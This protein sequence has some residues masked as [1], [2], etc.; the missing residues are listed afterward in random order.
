MANSIDTSLDCLVNYLREQNLDDEVFNKTSYATDPLSDACK[1]RIKSELDLVFIDAHQKYEDKKEFKKQIDC[2]ID[3]IK[4]DAK[5]KHFLL[6]KKAIESIKLSWR[7]KLN[8]KNWI[9]G[10]KKKALKS[11][12]NDIYA[13]EFE[14]LFVCEYQKTFEGV[15]VSITEIEKLRERN[16]N[17]EICIRKHLNL[18]NNADLDCEEL[19]KDVKAEIFTNLKELYSG[20][21]KSVRKCID[22]SIKSED[23][24]VP[25][26]K[27]KVFMLSDNQ[28]D[29]EKEKKSFVESM[30]DLMRKALTKCT[31]K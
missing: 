6:K 31:K 2:F 7:A 16:S 15:F 8:P 18:T 17:Q 23:F 4:N 24:V 26:F 14:N 10:K 13:I 29:I 9:A 21:K 20:Q 19:L 28:K 30:M 3:S 12:E 25:I 27:V 11:V 5:F 1:R 22:E